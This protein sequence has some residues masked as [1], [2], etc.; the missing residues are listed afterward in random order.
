MSQAP[1][2][3]HPV[4]R[5]PKPGRLTVLS[6]QHVL[7]FYA[8]AVVVPLVVAGGLRLDAYTTMHLINADLFTCGIATL[9]QSVGFWKVGVRLPIIQGVTTTAVSPMIAI[10]LAVTG[11]AGG[12]DG[13]PMIYGA[14]IVSGIFTFIAAPFFARIIRFFPPVVIGTV[15]ATMGI[16]LLGVSAGDIINRVDEASPPMPIAMRDLG[17][18]ALTLVIIIIVQRFFKGF[19]G[20]ISVLLGLVIGTAVALI[21]GD[22]SFS[23][24]SEASAFGFTTPFYFG[25]PQFS[26]TACISMIIVMII[27]MVETTGDVFAAGEI[28]SK[29]ITRNHIAAA[30]R[31]DGL[32]TTLGGIFNSFPYT[33]FAQNVGLVRLTRVKSRWVVALAGVFMIVLGLIPKAGAIVAAIPAPVLGGASLA[34]FANVALVGFQTL[35]RVDLAD[36]RNAVILTTSLGLAM[37]VSFKPDIA[38]VFPSWAQIFFASGVTVGS[39]TA[40]VLNLLFFH[41]G[42]KRGE[43]IALSPTGRRVSLGQINA[44]DKDAFVR[45]FTT[46]YNGATWPLERAWERRPFTD[47][48]QLKEILQ[49]A[50]LSASSTDQDALVQNYPDIVEMLVADEDQARAISQ[51]VGS[52]ALGDIEGDQR[53]QLEALSASYRDKFGIPFVVC[54][55]RMDSVDDIIEQGLHR[56]ENSP[57]MERIVAIGEVGE[58]VSD[59]FDIMLADANPVRTAWARK[60]EQLN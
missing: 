49:D 14:I 12:V 10:G 44:M 53:E 4:D 39:I 6:I 16:T 23:Q 17:Y 41:V 15:L 3:L 22:A 50:A 38:N 8:G 28:V 27:T 11:P 26:A 59:R 57:A 1:A 32:S 13:L 58:V 47:V 2:A 37:L 19:L 5:V 29:R 21:L 42:P 20:T 48:G 46:L 18:A 31:A 25:L 52:F 56:L 30:L 43:N 35:G 54:L 55:E 24:V 36:T 60:F 45:T 34:L 33:C 51:D 9:I 40:I 7:A